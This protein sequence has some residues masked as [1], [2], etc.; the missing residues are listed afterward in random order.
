MSHPTPILKIMFDDVVEFEAIVSEDV[1]HF[2]VLKDL[3]NYEPMI[4]ELITQGHTK[5]I[6]S[7]EEEIVFED[8][9]VYKKPI[10]DQQH[11]SISSLSELET[12]LTTNGFACIV[13]TALQRAFT[14]IADGQDIGFGGNI[15]SPSD[16]SILMQSAASLYKVA[17]SSSYD[18][19]ISEEASSYKLDVSDA[20]INP[21]PVQFLKRI[22][23]DLS[24]STFSQE[25]YAN[26]DRYKKSI[27]IIRET[28]RVKHLDSLRFD[29][30]GESYMVKRDAI[31][32][33]RRSV[34]SWMNS[35][36]VSIEVKDPKAFNDEHE[37]S[38]KVYLPEAL[39]V[40]TSQSL[41]KKALRYKSKTMKI[42]GSYISAKT[43]YADSIAL[44]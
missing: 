10:Y 34:A 27:E 20:D 38:F 29:I 19:I 11:I 24:T 31:A 36:K 35:S 1:K 13:D 26:D 7:K 23:Q 32:F 5:N 8:G 4:K 21:E 9:S 6:L 25:L 3:M 30:D 43:I 41:Y 14:V 28:F 18:P 2:R 33:I 37:F 39:T 16:R 40:K 22:V 44:L 15:I 42:T 12:F 17:N